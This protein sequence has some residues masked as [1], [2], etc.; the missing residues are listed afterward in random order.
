MTCLRQCRRVVALL[1]LLCCVAAGAV[2]GT[3]VLIVDL[4]VNHERMGD[5]FV[6]L[7]DAGNYYI[8]EAA[9]RY[10]QIARPWPEPLQFK[11]ESYYGL[12]Q[13]YGATAELDHQRLE[14]RLFLPA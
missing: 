14:L 9:L 12:H 10:W 3:R 8:D 5:A 4:Y 2:E 11:G 1:L 7:D 6:L 13:F